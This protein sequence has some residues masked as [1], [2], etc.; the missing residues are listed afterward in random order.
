MKALRKAAILVAATFTIGGGMTT[1]PAAPVQAK[2]KYV[3]TAPAHGTKYH[4]K[5]HCRGL[6]NAGRLRHVTLKW[7]KHHHYKLCKW[8]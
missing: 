7:A 2:T 8:G 4:Y 5:K 3:W 1:V 6:N